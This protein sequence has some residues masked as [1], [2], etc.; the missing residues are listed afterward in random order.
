MFDLLAR[1]LALVEFARK[2]LDLFGGK[3]H[4]LNKGWMLLCLPS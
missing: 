1:A 4:L 3:A 2:R